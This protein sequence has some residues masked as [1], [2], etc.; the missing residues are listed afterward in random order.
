MHCTHYTL[1]SLYKAIFE[2]CLENVPRMNLQCHACENGDPALLQ[3]QTGLSLV[4]MGIVQGGYGYCVLCVVYWVLCVGYCVLC[5]VCWV[6]C[7]M[8]CAL[9]VAHCV[10]RSVCCAV[11]VVQCVFTLQEEW[12]TK[13]THPTHIILTIHI[14][15]AIHTAGGMALRRI[16]PD[17]AGDGK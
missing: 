15:L 4:G 8:C 2:Y 6:L 17:S 7:I 13:R 11:C 3:E 12:H 9:C 5:V 1:Y 10:L 14:A 16:R